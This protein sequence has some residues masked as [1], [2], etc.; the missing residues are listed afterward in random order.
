MILSSPLVAADAR[1]RSVFLHHAL[2]RHAK[3]LIRIFHGA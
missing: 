3:P 2:I 1:I